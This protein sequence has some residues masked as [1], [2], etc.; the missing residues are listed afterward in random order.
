MFTLLN[1]DKDGASTHAEGTNGTEQPAPGRRTT[2]STPLSL[3]LQQNAPNPFADATTLR[4]DLAEDAS[5][6]LTVLDM[7]GN[8]VAEL[9]NLDQRQG[10]YELA[11]T[12]PQT[13]PSGTYFVRLTART[14]KGALVQRNIALQ[15]IK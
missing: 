1:L 13:L 2:E 15:R 5:V 14:S 7:T 4:Y 6:S 3:T 11:W 10:S 9:V 8:L 12:P